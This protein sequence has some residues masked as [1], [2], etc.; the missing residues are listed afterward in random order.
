MFAVF[1]VFTNALVVQ[2]KW[3]IKVLVSLLES[4]QLT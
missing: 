4:R 3:G 1:T 2:K